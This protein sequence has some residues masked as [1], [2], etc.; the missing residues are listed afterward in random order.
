MKLNIEQS[1]EIKALSGVLC[2]AALLLSAI[3]IGWVWV[4][5]LGG[6]K[7][8]YYYF[9]IYSTLPPKYFPQDSNII[10]QA[11]SPIK[12][13][14]YALLMGSIFLFLGYFKNKN[15]VAV[16]FYCWCVRII[17]IHDDRYKIF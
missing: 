4:Q 1:T 15:A 2:V 3:P 12:D 11:Y 13:F 7:P 8:D 10:P 9:T 17:C 14:I 6:E 16:S 5:V